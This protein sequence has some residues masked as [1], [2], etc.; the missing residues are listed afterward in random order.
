MVGI[1]I[2]EWPA[3]LVGCHCRRLS[4]LIHPS[5]GVQVTKPHIKVEIPFHLVYIVFNAIWEG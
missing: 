4:P 5:S 1:G 2:T 3:F